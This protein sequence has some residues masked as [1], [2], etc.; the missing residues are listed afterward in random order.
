MKIIVAADLHLD[1]C[2]WV[3]HPTMRG[4]SFYAFEQIIDLCIANVA[5]LVLLGDV[6]EQA[7]PDP[8]VVSHYLAGITR[9]ENARIAVYYVQGD[10]D[11]NPRQAWAGLHPWATHVDQKTFDLGGLRCYGLDFRPRGVIQ[12]KLRDVPPEVDIL[13][14]HLGWSDLQ[15]IGA[16]N[17]DAS[18]IYN[19][20]H[21]MSGDYHSRTEVHSL[22]NADGQP[23][24]IIS[25]GSTNV[26]SWGEVGPEEH[27]CKSV[28]LLTTLEGQEDLPEDAEFGWMPV[29]LRGR[30]FLR[31]ELSTEAELD[32]LVSRPYAEFPVITG[33]P[34]L[35]LPAV[36]FRYPSDLP[37]AHARLR[38]YFLDR[39]HLFFEPQMV[40]ADEVVVDIDAT[41]AGA[42]D[43]LLSAITELA[44]DPQVTADLSELLTSNDP[45]ECLLAQRALFVEQQQQGESNAST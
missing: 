13:F 23:T 31:V 10:H 17:A 32:E 38:Q 21:V 12:Q 11:Y 37:E 24:R 34:E 3:K 6:F 40:T 14:T 20:Q 1:L 22:P 33:H 7:R 25:P 4:D 16:T 39:A 29:T 35:T 19:T 44:T 36:R 42:F 9:L 15:G 18:D 41:P 27:H 8:E 28:L 26:R 43:D 30:Q 5:P 2:T 45:R